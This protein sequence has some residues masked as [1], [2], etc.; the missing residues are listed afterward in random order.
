ML[1]RRR[2]HCGAPKCRHQYTNERMREFQRRHKAETGVSY[3]SKYRGP[4]HAEKL[5]A[6]H[7]ARKNG[8]L[9]PKDPARQQEAW[10][11]R[12]ARKQ[13][14]P[15]EKFR[16]IDVYERDGW[17]CQLCTEP[18]DPELRY[19]DRMSASL[20]H[21]TPLSRGGHHTWENVQLAHLICNTRKCARIAEEEPA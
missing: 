13:A 1:P 6:L 3:V 21:V 18:V 10:Q 11:R 16:H 14:L 5:A 15:V 4:E 17:I 7:Q 8:E 2:K 9:P 20:D 12:R 19:P